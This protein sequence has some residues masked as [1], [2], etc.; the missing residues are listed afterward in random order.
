MTSR[1]ASAQPHPPQAREARPA[2]ESPASWRKAAAAA[3]VPTRFV[4]NAAAELLSLLDRVHAHGWGRRGSPREWVELRPTLLAKQAAHRAAGGPRR[5]TYWRG[6]VWIET[7]GVA[8]VRRLGKTISVRSLARDPAVWASLFNDAQRGRNVSQQGATKPTE[9]GAIATQSDYAQLDPAGAT[10]PSGRST[11]VRSTP[12]AFEKGI[13]RGIG[14]APKASTRVRFA[15]HSQKGK[16]NRQDP[17]RPLPLSDPEEAATAMQIL[18]RIANAGGAVAW[19]TETLRSMLVHFDAEGTAG[20]VLDVI[21]RDVLPRWETGEIEN[22]IAYLRKIL[23]DSGDQDGRAFGVFNGSVKRE[24]NGA[25]EEVAPIRR[26]LIAET[27][28]RVASA[29][30]AA[31]ARPPTPDPETVRRL[32]EPADSA[33][34]SAQRR[35]LDDAERRRIHE[36]HERKR[37]REAFREQCAPILLELDDLAKGNRERFDAIRA[38]VYPRGVGTGA[39]Y[40]ETTAD[41]LHALAESFRK[42][43]AALVDQGEEVYA[44][45]ANMPQ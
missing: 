39:A 44:N 5:E 37:E 32:Q 25:A 23:R 9:R 13:E 43:A 26:G 6:I 40:E 10:S 8:Q 17:T 30:G 14:S 7:H 15:S 35:A 19:K 16:E 36:E 45:T 24:S 11:P 21:E 3:G 1:G 31:P 4:P 2:E 12:D 28:V 41:Q 38:I 22:P 33:P 29:L 20:G 34:P 27:I 18:Q 42:Q